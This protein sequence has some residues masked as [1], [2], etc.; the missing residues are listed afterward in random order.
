[1]ASSSRQFTASSIR[2]AKP[3]EVED[4]DEDDGPEEVQAA[5]PQNPF[6]DNEKGYRAWLEGEGRQF[7]EHHRSRNWLGGDVTPF[8]LNPTFKPPPPVSD[9]TRTLIYQ[10]FMA[11]PTKNSVRELAALHGLS[12][13]RVDAI[14]RL[15]G[16]EEHWKKEGK[17]LQTGFQVGME[18]ILGVAERRKNVSAT[19]TAALS[20]ETIKADIQFDEEGNDLKAR[21]RYQRL[22]WEPTAE[23]Q[24]PIIPDILEK[25]RKSPSKKDSEGPVRVVERPGRPEMRFVDVGDKFVDPKELKKR[26]RDAAHRAHLRARRQQ[27]KHEAI[28][29][30][31]APVHAHA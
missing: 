22:F 19:A 26:A 23:G 31:K 16:L 5:A 10:Q 8:P 29:A 25:N 2:R 11:D 24:E 4:F 6:P 1:M 28:A 18:Y 12:I 9:A 13:A 7:K 20:E 15:K 17:Q 3:E 30:A 14:L 21:E 27:K